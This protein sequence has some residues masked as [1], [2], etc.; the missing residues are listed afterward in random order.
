M[1]FDAPMPPPVSDG[2][3]QKTPCFSLEEAI[4]LPR[5]IFDQAKYGQKLGQHTATLEKFSELLCRQQMPHKD[6]RS[7]QQGA[8]EK[9]RAGAKHK[10]SA[11]PKLFFTRNLKKIDTC[12]F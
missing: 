11:S 9:W 4:D 3:W 7:L 8:T 1:Q 10:K 2:Q 6:G 5:N 12:H